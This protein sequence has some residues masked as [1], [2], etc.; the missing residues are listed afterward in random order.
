MD[1]VY[2]IVNSS[3]RTDCNRHP[4]SVRLKMD[5]ASNKLSHCVKC[6]SRIPKK[7]YI[8]DLSKS[9]H[10]AVLFLLV[11]TQLVQAHVHNKTHSIPEALG[12][13]SRNHQ[14]MSN[15]TETY[16]DSMHRTHFFKPFY[17]KNITTHLRNAS[18]NQLKDK[19]V[20]LAVIA[21]QDPT[22][23]FSL[24]KIL[25][26]IELASKAVTDPEKGYLPG[27]DIQVDFR[28]SQCSSVEG[29]LAAFEF[30]IN[31][32]A[33]IAPSL[34]SLYEINEISVNIVFV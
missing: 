22:H 33:G 8:L 7:Y 29:P 11:W 15:A 2:N 27:W 32:K 21:P 14:R 3:N 12:S 5:S 1:S 26:M 23:E 30:Y 20:R 18:R 6:R 13:D 16:E 25:P 34:Y 4:K 24:R 10:F 19:Q 17:V 9:K 31:D 28:D